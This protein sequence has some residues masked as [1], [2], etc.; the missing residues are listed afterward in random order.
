HPQLIESEKRYVD[1]HPGMAV[2]KAGIDA[3][4]HRGARGHC[5]QADSS[6]Q[7]AFENRELLQHGIPVRQNSF[8]PFD[9]TTSLSCEALKPLV[10]Q[11]D[12]SAELRFQLFDRV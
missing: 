3:R 7:R 5:S 1:L 11:N 2:E 4:Q 9:D 10:P 6:R 8:G 12:R